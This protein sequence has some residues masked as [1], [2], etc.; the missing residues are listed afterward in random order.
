[1]PV[2]IGPD[3]TQLAEARGLLQDVDTALFL[4][5]RDL[6]EVAI[7]LQR[8]RA[9]HPEVRDIGA[10]SRPDQVHIL[11]ADSAAAIVLARFASGA[12][13]DSPVSASGLSRVDSVSALLGA[14][15]TRQWV[16]FGR[17]AF[18]TPE[19]PGWV[20]VHRAGALYEKLPDVRSA[21]WWLD[22]VGGSGGHI[23]LQ[24][25]PGRWRLT[26]TRGWGD[27]PSGCIYYR[28]YTFDYDPRSDRVARVGER[29]DPYPPPKDEPSP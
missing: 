17:L 14:R 10:G 19:I 12:P 8:V 3:S 25:L 28:A 24:R 29:G 27:C 26:F 4:D 2:P 20:N 18:L 23:Q 5:E 15:T 9:R 6:R 16:A 21:P 1:M 13:N 22:P 7:G 11:L